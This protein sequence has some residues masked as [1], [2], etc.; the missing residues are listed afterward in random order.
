M[1]RAQS[2]LAPVLYELS[3]IRVVLIS[4]WTT[5]VTTDTLQRPLQQNRAH[6]SYPLTIPQGPQIFLLF[7]TLSRIKSPQSPLAATPYFRRRRII[8]IKM[9]YNRGRSSGAVSMN[10]GEE[11]HCRLIYICYI[12]NYVG[13]HQSIRVIRSQRSFVEWGAGVLFVRGCSNGH[14]WCRHPITKDLGP[15]TL[16][17]SHHAS[18]PVH[19]GERIPNIVCRPDIPP[20][21]SSGISPWFW[22]CIF[23]FWANRGR[24]LSYK[25]CSLSSMDPSPFRS[26]DDA[27][28][29][30]LGGV[31][32]S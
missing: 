17:P 16:I 13:I 12:I 27:E 19:W 18:I 2:L 11:N 26:I 23:Q 15:Q 22:G 4:R 24:F 6:H 5:A 25:F 29:K 30:N 14:N 28:E 8:L 10:L 32:Q 7:V 1:Q 9:T 3:W 20:C 31:W 21:S